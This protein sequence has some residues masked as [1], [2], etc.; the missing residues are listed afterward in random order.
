MY[1]ETRFTVA[2][3]ST[4]V[5]DISC[6]KMIDESDWH[7]EENFNYR[8]ACSSSS[9]QLSVEMHILYDHTY[10]VGCPFIRVTD[11]TGKYFSASEFAKILSIA[12]DATLK[13]PEAIDGTEEMF[14]SP[15]Q[16]RRFLVSD[17]YH[18]ILNKPFIQPHLCRQVFEVWETYEIT[19]YSLL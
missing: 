2:V 6:D 9:V 3:N 8:I 12:M 5:D 13:V 16:N 7:C 10:K 14:S 1:L 4:V 18:P 15:N 17:E 19:P 11:Q